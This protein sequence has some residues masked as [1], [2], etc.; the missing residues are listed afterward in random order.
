MKSSIL[1]TYL[2]RQI[3]YYISIIDILT[4]LH[5]LLICTH[6]TLNFCIQ[7][8]NVQRMYI[9]RGQILVQYCRN[10]RILTPSEFQSKNVLIKLELLYVVF[11]FRCYAACSYG[12]PPQYKE[13]SSMFLPTLLKQYTCLY[14]HAVRASCAR[15]SPHGEGQ[16]NECTNSIAT[17]RVQ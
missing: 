11:L 8:T 4:A 1:T 12:Q 3:A 17:L 6:S 10:I 14:R 13:Q 7:R 16:L 9:F 5:N 15:R 2:C